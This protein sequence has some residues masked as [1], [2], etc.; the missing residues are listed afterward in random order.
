MLEDEKK[1]LVLSRGED[2]KILIEVV[3]SKNVMRTR[4]QGENS[5]SQI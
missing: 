1:L 5:K 4:L 3:V 2:D